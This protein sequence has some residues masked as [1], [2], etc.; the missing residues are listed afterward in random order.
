MFNLAMCVAKRS[1]LEG[2][3]RS[4]ESH[5]RGK[6]SLVIHYQPMGS[7]CKIQELWGMEALVRWGPPGAGTPGAFRVRARRRGERPGDTDGG[8]DP[9]AG[10]LF[11]GAK[12]WQEEKPHGIPSL[13]MSVELLCLAALPL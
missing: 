6:R 3:E 1:R 8:T 9:Y 2:G 12:E 5:R 4:Q 7:I 11:P 10:C 13:V